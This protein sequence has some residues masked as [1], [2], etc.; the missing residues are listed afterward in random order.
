M[1]KLDQT[2]YF[3]LLSLW[4]LICSGQNL[5]K[6]LLRKRKE[7]KLSSLFKFKP[8]STMRRSISKSV[9]IIDRVRNKMKVNLR[10]DSTHK[11]MILRISPFMIHH[12]A[13]RHLISFNLTLVQN[14]IS[15]FD[16]IPKSFRKTSSNLFVISRSKKSRYQSN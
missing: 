11:M 12:L 7:N 3:F 10:S 16:R 2:G 4:N 9:R 6:I 14:P 8:R 15:I 5:S 1:K 13:K